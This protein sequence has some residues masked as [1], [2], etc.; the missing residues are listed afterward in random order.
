M[1]KQQ[2]FQTLKDA[3]YSD[4]LISTWFET[5]QDE[6]NVNEYL[7]GI[8]HNNKEYNRLKNYLTKEQFVKMLYSDYEQQGLPYGLI[9]PLMI[10]SCPSIKNTFLAMEFAKS[11]KIS[12]KNGM[13][14]VDMTGN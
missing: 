8:T 12:Y 13:T 2:F 7:K 1:T 11:V 10:C 14:I 3:P 4:E 5:F 6:N 9:V